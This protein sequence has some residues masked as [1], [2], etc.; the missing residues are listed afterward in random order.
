MQGREGGGREVR[1]TFNVVFLPA[2]DTDG[3]FKNK[4]YF[5]CPPKHGKIVRITNVVAVLPP[6]V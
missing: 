5:T 4:R 1:T 3:L 6:K 2:G